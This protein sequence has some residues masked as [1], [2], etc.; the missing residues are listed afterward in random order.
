MLPQ[1]TYHLVRKLKKEYDLPVEIHAHN[2]FGFGTAD[3]VAAVCA[4]AD[5][6][7]TAVNGLGEG[8]GNTALE[9]VTLALQ[10]MLGIEMGMNFAK[11]YE[12]CKL[13][14]K[15]SNVPLQSTK[16]LV[17]DKV[18]TTES[19]IAVSRLFRMKEKGIPLMPY[20]DSLYPEVIGRTKGVMI[21]KKSGRASIEYKLKELGMDVPPAEVQQ[22]ILEGVKEYSLKNKKA[23]PDK[24][25]QTIVK[26]VLSGK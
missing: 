22:K 6:V 4:G 21:G 24:A 25:F 2:F 19:G 10:M 14:E 12:L 9:E 8:A 15:L 20:S 23:V 11:T 3:A 16:P 1:A 7:H 5:V 13:V 26:K 17:G 18:F